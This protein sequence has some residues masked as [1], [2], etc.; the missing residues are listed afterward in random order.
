MYGKQGGNT[1]SKAFSRGEVPTKA[2]KKLNIFSKCSHRRK[3][4]L[5]EDVLI[6]L[7]G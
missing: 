1:L 7:N 2:A 3:P 4:L 5:L 6:F